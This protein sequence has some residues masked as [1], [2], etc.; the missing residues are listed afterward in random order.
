[1]DT[2]QG[3]C[4]REEL[5]VYRE[6]R[7]QQSM[8][9][10]GNFFFGPGSLLL[11]GA[12]TFLYELF[13]GEGGSPDEAT[14]MSFFGV[15]KTA[16]GAYVAN[17]G[18][19]AP[20]NWRPR[21]EPYTGRNTVEEILAMYNA[22]PVQFGG[23]IGQGNF[24]GLNFG[25]AIQDG[26]LVEQGPA[27]LTCLIFQIVASGFPATFGEAINLPVSV[28][29]QITDELAPFASNLGCPVNHK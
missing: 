13:P 3:N 9:E 2:C 23:N 29:N 8:Q 6:Q 16:D 24:N 10:N 4:G 7:W 1:M 21:I 25:E 14:M 22:N 20:P 11:Y 28:L 26:T 27:A 12:A 5:S 17:S 19:R 15:D 18:E